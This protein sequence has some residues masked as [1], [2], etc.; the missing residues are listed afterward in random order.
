MDLYEVV[1]GS[2]LGQL[3]FLLFHAAAT[4]LFLSVQRIS[5][6]IC[7]FFKDVTIYHHMTLL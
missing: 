1:M 2:N 7:I 5:A 4:L 6:L 3:K